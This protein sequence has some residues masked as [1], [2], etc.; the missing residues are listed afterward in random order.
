[1]KIYWLG[2]TCTIFSYKYFSLLTVCTVFIY[3]ESHNKFSLKQYYEQRE[4]S[5][6]SF[7]MFLFLFSI[8]NFKKYDSFFSFQCQIKIEKKN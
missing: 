5:I 2:A 3:I 1:M 8:N 6:L 4:I 7:I